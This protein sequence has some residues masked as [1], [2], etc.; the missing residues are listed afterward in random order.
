MEIDNQNFR[1]SLILAII[2]PPVR[3]LCARSGRLYQAIR[4]GAHGTLGQ[5]PEV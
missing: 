5:R 3:P 1:F 2:L 4:Q